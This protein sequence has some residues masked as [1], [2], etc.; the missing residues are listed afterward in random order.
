MALRH[1]PIDAQRRLQVLPH[2]HSQQLR[3]ALFPT[4]P[5]HLLQISPENLIAQVLALALQQTLLHARPCHP[6]QSRSRKLYRK[7]LWAVCLRHPLLARRTLPHP[8]AK[9]HT[10][11]TIEPHQHPRLRL[12]AG[13]P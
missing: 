2:H 3:K 9:P 7:Q 4:N 6:V 8:P 11:L 5:S 10:S 1:Q 13:S 12:I